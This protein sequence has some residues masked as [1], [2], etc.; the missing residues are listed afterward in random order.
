MAL[1]QAMSLAS[2]SAIC[3]CTDRIA[4]G[5][6]PARPSALVTA[7]Q[8]APEVLALAGGAIDEDVDGLEPQGAQTAL[9]AGLETSRATYSMW[10]SA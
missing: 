5:P 3:A 4:G 7:G 9:V 10:I 8:I 2:T 6:R 1:C